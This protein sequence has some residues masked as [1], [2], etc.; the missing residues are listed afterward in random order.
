MKK[1]HIITLLLTVSMVS[2]NYLDFDEN[3]AYENQKDLY[4]TFELAESMLTDVY[5]YLPQDFGNF[6]GAMQDCATDDAVYVQSYSSI[7]SFYNGNWSQVSPI[8]DQWSEFYS[9]VRA[10]NQ[11]IENMSNADFSDY[12]YDVNYPANMERAS[13]WIYEARFLRAFFLFELA[14]R[15]GDIPIADKI[16][17]REDA[18]KMTKSKFSDVIDY[19]CAECYEVAKYL[20]KSYLS[21]A[22][23]QTGRATKGAA[24]A[25]RSRAMLYK[26]SPLHNP[27]NN[28]QLWKDA[29]LAA[30]EVIDSK[31]YSFEGVANV[32]N[33]LDAKELIFERRN[34][35]SNTFEA[36]NTPVGFEQGGTGNCPTEDLVSSYHTSGGHKVT[37]TANGWTSTDPL[38]D[39]Q[40]PY[41][42][43]DPRLNRTVLCDGDS[44]KGITIESFYNG[45]NGA[46]LALASPT[47]YYLKK[48]MIESIN[49][50]PSATTAIHTW[51]IFRYA[52]IVLNYA[53]AMNEA[54]GADYKDATYKLSARE[55][56]N[57][58]RKNAAMPEIST[59]KSQ[60][61]VKALIQ[62]ERR[63]ELAFEGHRFWDV[64]R[65]KI[66]MQTQTSVN[67]VAITKNGNKKTYSIQLVE[68]R[69]WDEKM[70]LYPISQSELLKN[71]NLLPQNFGWN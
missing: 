14:K 42:N 41:A 27:T 21:V 9:A 39:P 52:E 10:A 54:F 67:G 3:D 58:V 29:A 64:R 71:G 55:A 12:E 6:S 48:Y 57:M 4:R 38:F 7:K 18:N 23:S 5:S 19:I 59:G 17:T 69:T 25:L 1:Y 43:R 37:L 22:G 45:K 49:L 68:N 28:E 2:C 24:Q 51:S 30:Q 70:N 36:G 61:E 20:P 13:K 53:E 56:Y 47:G 16:Y 15:Y 46:P 35:A 31:T 40:N 65:W 26:A 33:N 44:W 60:P 8:D 32:L 63:C 50:A 11:F 66:G 34:K 62:N